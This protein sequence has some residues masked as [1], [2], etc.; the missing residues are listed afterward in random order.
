M[1]QSAIQL[2]T[3]QSVYHCV[4]ECEA[5][6]LTSPITNKC[7]TL[8]H[9]LMVVSNDSQRLHCREGRNIHQPD[10]FTFHPFQFIRASVIISPHCLFTPQ[11]YIRVTLFLVLTL[12]LIVTEIKVQLCFK[13]IWEVHTLQPLT[14]AFRSYLLHEIVQL[15]NERA[16]YQ[17]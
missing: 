6:I 7:K 3:V 11:A 9:T 10:F 13:C 17:L 12:H 2:A 15:S 4:L 1:Y 16:D 5:K 8:W 14:V